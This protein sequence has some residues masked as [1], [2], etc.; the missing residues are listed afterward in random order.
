MARLIDNG[1]CR[2]GL[3]EN[4][5]GRQI[6]RLI[7]AVE[8]ML[9][10]NISVAAELAL[11]ATE[12]VINIGWVKHD[13]HTTTESTAAISAAVEQLAASISEL[14]ENS[15]TSARQAEETRGRMH[16]CVE[17]GH[18]AVQAMHAIDSRVSNIGER[19]SVFEA[20]SAKIGAMAGD[21]DAIARQTNLLALNATIEAARAGEAG[22]GFS[23]VAQEVKALAAQTAKATEEIH[24]RLVLLENEMREIRTAVD[25]SHRAVAGG[26]EIV[27]NVGGMVEAAGQEMANIADRTRNISEL[28]R[29]QRDATNEISKSANFITGKAAKT[30]VEIN[31]IQEK[32]T[33]AGE[34]ARQSFEGSECQT[35]NLPLLRLPA[36]AAVWKSKLAAILMLRRAGASRGAGARPLRPDDAH[37]QARRGEPAGLR[38]GVATAQCLRYGGAPGHADGR[39]RQDAGLGQG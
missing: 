30:D 23:V 36:D 19:L 32:L 6:G 28:L 35:E 5:S 20:T 21:I 9:E 10:P 15:A 34:M 7:G 12:A 3:P 1:F 11:A 38:A 27:S 8:E 4:A 33:S 17:S 14:L 31:T 26:N 39:C 24:N 25:E 22:K 16:Q 13:V 29:Q 2:D 37:R 18:A